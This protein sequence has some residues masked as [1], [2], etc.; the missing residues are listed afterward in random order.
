MLGN[1]T[2]KKKKKKNFVISFRN[3][4]LHDSLQDF[5]FS[6]QENEYQ[7]TLTATW[8]KITLSFKVVLGP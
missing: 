6:S 3:F 8:F 4:L 2:F 7:G 5:P 1:D